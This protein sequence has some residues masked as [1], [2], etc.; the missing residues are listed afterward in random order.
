[1]LFSGLDIQVGGAEHGLL[2]PACGRIGQ[3]EFHPETK[4]EGIAALYVL[5]QAASLYAHA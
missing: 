3:R 2:N 4:L 1:M 5:L